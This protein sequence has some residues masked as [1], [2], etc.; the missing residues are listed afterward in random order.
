[1]RVAA[2][3]HLDG[4]NDGPEAL[5]L[6]EKYQKVAETVNFERGEEEKEKKEG[7]RR[8]DKERRKRLLNTKHMASH[9]LF[10]SY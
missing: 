8:G 5:F 4:G 1:M 6:S 7:K 2:I 9:G 10:S 3:V